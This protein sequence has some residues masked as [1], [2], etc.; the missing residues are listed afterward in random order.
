MIKVSVYGV[1]LKK[2]W[3][4]IISPSTVVQLNTILLKLL[5]GMRKEMVTPVNGKFRTIQVISCNSYRCVNLSD[6]TVLDA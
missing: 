1:N 6:M 5:N 2:L 4:E 3:L